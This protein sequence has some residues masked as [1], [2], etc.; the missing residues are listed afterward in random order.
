MNDL[1]T[2]KILHCP[3]LVGGNPYGLAKAERELGLDSVCYSVSQNYLNYP[4]DHFFLAS[5]PLSLQKLGPD[6]T[7]SEKFFEN[8][9]LSITI[10]VPAR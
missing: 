2:I 6:S 7:C 1:K 5:T 9:I 3:Y 4:A 8:M 10:S